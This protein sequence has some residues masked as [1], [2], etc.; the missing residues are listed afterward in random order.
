[1]EIDGGN[2]CIPVNNKAR[3]GGGK[4]KGN[5]TRDNTDMTCW[6]FVK[7]NCKRGDK[8]KWQH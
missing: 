6:D 5:N 3:K 7:G 4:G 8:C 2:A 1:M